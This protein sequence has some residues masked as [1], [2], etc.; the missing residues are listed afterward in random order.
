M[1]ADKEW[2]AKWFA[3]FNSRYFSGRLPVPGFYVSMAKTALGV[4]RWETGPGG[5]KRYRIGLSNYY[6][7]TE[8]DFKNTLL[9]EMVHYYIGFSGQRDTSAHGRLFRAWMER[10]NKEGWRISVSERSGGLVRRAG[11][12]AKPVLAL[13][14][15]LRGGQFFLSAVNPVYAVSIDKEAAANPLVEERGWLVSTDEYLGGFSK[16]RTLRGCKVDKE[17]YLRYA[18]KAKTLRQTL[19]NGG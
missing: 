6:E 2:M 12:S 14:L 11:A 15:K 16:V 19:Q 4:A 8:D 10:L 3:I 9:H 18:A 5:A 7:R 13:A 1:K 17:T